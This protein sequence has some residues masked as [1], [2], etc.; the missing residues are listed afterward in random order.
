MNQTRNEKNHTNPAL[1]S[2][3][4]VLSPCRVFLD[5]GAQKPTFVKGG[6]VSGQGLLQLELDP[7]VM[8]LAP[9]LKYLLGNPVG[10]RFQLGSQD[11]GLIDLLQIVQGPADH[12]QQGQE[13]LVP[14]F[15]GVGLFTRFKVLY[16]H[17]AGHS[18]VLGKVSDFGQALLEPIDDALLC[19]VVLEVCD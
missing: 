17:L 12:V 10:G 8:V 13:D 16:R 4:L 1:R 6:H 15:Q 7:Q 11:L 19:V 3:K 9:V 14:L 5:A 2:S 18:Q